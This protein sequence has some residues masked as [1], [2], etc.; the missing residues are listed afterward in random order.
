MLRACKYCKVVKSTLNINKSYILSEVVCTEQ[1][2]WDLFRSQTARVPW[3]FAENAKAPRKQ[4]ALVCK[5]IT[6]ESQCQL[7]EQNFQFNSKTLLSL[8][9]WVYAGVKL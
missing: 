1:C 7:S 6:L 4:L 2:L 8:T 5:H 9:V 3:T